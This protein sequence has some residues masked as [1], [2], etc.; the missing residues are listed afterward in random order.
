MFELG[1]HKS[2]LWRSSKDEWFGGTKGFYWGCNNAK[3]LDVRL[4]TMSSTIGKPESTVWVPSDRDSTWVKLYNKHKGKIDAGFGFEAFTTPP[5]AAFSSLDAKFTTASMAKELKTHALFGNPLGRTWDPTPADVNRV[6][7]IQPLVSNDWTILGPDAPP[8]PDKGATPSV[9]LEG[10]THFDVASNP[11]GDRP[12]AWHGTILAKSDAD[13]WLAAAFPLYERIVALEEAYKSKATDGKLS[14]PQTERLALLKYRQ[15]ANRWLAT[16]QLGRDVALDKTEFD[17]MQRAWFEI[18][19][20][21]G[22]NVLAALRSELGSAPFLKFMDEFG[23][24]HAGKAV[25]TSEFLAAAEEAKGKPLDQAT[26]DLIT[27]VEKPAAPSWSIDAFNQELDR[28]I[29]VTGTKKDVSA[30]REAAERLQRQIA[31]RWPNIYVTVKTDETATEADLKSNHVLLVGRPESNAAFAT[32]GSGLPV[33]FA[34]TS[35]SVDGQTYGHASSSVI[36]AGPNPL[37]PRFAVVA[38]SGL[39]AEA[40]WHCVEHLPGRFDEASNV[41]ILAVGS[42]PR[43][44]VVR[45]PEGKPGALSLRGE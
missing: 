12:P 27:R 39:G 22:V 4:E 34:G 38:F 6:P 36:A 8:L 24:T 44:L 11:E 2:K 30:Q 15:E 23:R 25:G 26:R 43:S 17:L 37:D 7:Q 19:A 40:T 35:F 10:K 1:T 45:T 18:A 42:R 21:K 29:I 9:D 41:M 32:L 28:T 20:A 16:L 33:K 14:K 31:R 3:D 5:L 13:T